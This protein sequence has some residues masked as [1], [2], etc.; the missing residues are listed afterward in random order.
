M[1]EKLH[2]ENRNENALENFVLIIKY[3]EEELRT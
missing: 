1:I 2:K 3:I